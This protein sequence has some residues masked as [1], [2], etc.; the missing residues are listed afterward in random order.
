MPIDAV[1]SGQITRFNT[2]NLTAAVLPETLIPKHPDELE[3]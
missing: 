1:F 2:N 3:I